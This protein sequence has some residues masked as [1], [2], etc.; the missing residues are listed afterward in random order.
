MGEDKKMT[1]N[2]VARLA[3]TSKTTVSFYLNGKT[4]RMSDETAER[5]KK[6]IEETHY[7]PSMAARSL[8]AKDSKLIGVIIGDITNTFSN[9]VVKGIG[10]IAAPRHYQMLVGNS[11]YSR[12]SEASYIDKMLAV[13]V[14]G[15]IVQPTARF[16]GLLPRI[17]SA[18]KPI[19]FFD[20]KLYDPT[21]SWVKTNNYEATYEAVSHAIG[22]GYEASIVISANPKLLSTRIE[23]FSGFVDA[24]EDAGIKHD[25]LMF[26]GDSLDPA[27]VE[28]F[29]SKHLV[30]SVRTL[31]FVPNCWAL[32]SVFTAMKDLGCGIPDPVGLLSFDN[33]EWCKFSS[34]TVSTIVQ[35]TYE[36]GAEACRILL[37]QIDGKDSLEKNQVLDCTVEWRGSTL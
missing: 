37:D 18:D 31:I 6:V 29:L 36:E 30:A 21:N 32:P 1:I 22:E 33:T 5:I 25:D 8:N 10:S 11:D 28:A 14:D 3:D 4:D 19:V 26:D 15:F 16:R 23:R 12:E 17:E 7:R 13:G 27:K 20:S 34:P 35:P 2:D 9:Q 24:V